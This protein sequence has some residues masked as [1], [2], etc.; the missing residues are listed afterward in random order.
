MVL[1]KEYERVL[2]RLREIPKIYDEHRDWTKAHREEF[3]RLNLRRDE[4][5]RKLGVMI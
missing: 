5:R 2:V 4:L 3:G 1:Q